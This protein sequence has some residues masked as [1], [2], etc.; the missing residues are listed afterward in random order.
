M[1]A[2]EIGQ[3][4]VKLIA[5]NKGLN[6]G[7]DESK[8]KIG[9]L[10]DKVG[11][12][13]GVIKTSFLA[14]G[15]GAV[16]AGAA[17]A[18]FA[19]DGV[20][21]T[22]KLADTADALNATVTG[23]RAVSAAAGDKSIDGMESSLA[24]L[25]RRLGEAMG[26]NEIA[27]E[28][29]KKLG[30]STK[31]LANSDADQRVAKIANAIKAQGLN[32]A[33][34]GAALKELGFA[35]EN[36]YALFKD[37]GDA[38]RDQRKEIEATG[39][40][41]SE[42]DAIKV[43]EAQKALGVFGDRI[44]AIQTQLAVELAP[45]IQAVSDLFAEWT[46]ESVDGS[47]KVKDVVSTLVDV[48]AFV[49]DAADG[50][51]RTGEVLGVVLAQAA[52]AAKIRFL[53]AG[54][55]IINAI[56]AV[57]ALIELSNQ[58]L[59]TDFSKFAPNVDW[60][61][62]IKAGYETMGQMVGELQEILMRPMSSENIKRFV[63]EAKAVQEKSAQEILENKRKNAAALSAVEEEIAEDT[64]E[65][66]RARLEAEKMLYQFDASGTTELL[67]IEH[68]QRE[69]DLIDSLNKKL[70]TETEFQSASVANWNQY[71]KDLANIDV[72]TN[73]MRMQGAAQMFGNL[74]T[75]M[76]TKSHELFEIGKT[77]A[78]A[79]TVVTTAM[80]AMEAY[81]W[82]MKYG[83]IAAPAVATAAAG[84]AI[85]AGGV[86]LAAINQ[87]K[88]SA[89]G[90]APSASVTQNINAQSAPVQSQTQTQAPVQDIYVR[91]VST[92][93][94]YSGQ[95]LIDIINEGIKSGGRIV[96]V[97]A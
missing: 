45:V 62:E 25:N 32:A 81:A 60:T 20:T 5:D 12:A 27:A 49:A 97:G 83:G 4:V 74:S 59:G 39:R 34:A 89:G 16:A 88:F 50:A 75:L 70:I 11:A 7:T 61:D 28:S 35:Q 69:L 71:Q 57:N 94:M 3:I 33:Q 92:D 47:S 82:G 51:A 91:G 10:S 53:E 40:A 77:A 76:N 6:D 1:A 30:L 36:A 29:F 78:Y 56:N 65:S 63:E 86:Q 72:Q 23:L 42:I 15:A 52:F 66:V 31:D 87:Q 85:V 79:N 14:I 44:E 37:G 19:L 68:M 17:F 95:Q 96:G 24:R 46:Q 93:S 8:K 22:A 38:I 21:M 48:F 73:K 2:T 58:F 18:K 41:L 64:Y 67:R 55:A 13:E 9:E 90:A 80:A 84:A 43:Q 54:Q 26:G